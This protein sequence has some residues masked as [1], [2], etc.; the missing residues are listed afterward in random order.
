MMEKPP[1]I[2]TPKP[3]KLGKKLGSGLEK[4]VYTDENNPNQ[5][6]AIHGTERSPE[7]TKA[8]FY[9]TNIFHMLYPNIFRHVRLMGARGSDKE[10]HPYAIMD[11]IE[12]GKFHKEINNLQKEYWQAKD[13]NARKDILNR[14]RIKISE[15]TRSPKYNEFLE[16]LKKMGTSIEPDSLI[17]RNPANYNKDEKGN[18]QYIEEIDPFTRLLNW[19]ELD[20]NPDVL[21]KHIKERLQSE[22]QQRALA[23]LDRIKTLRKENQAKENKERAWLPPNY[24]MD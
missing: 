7:E 6:V 11:E 17:D 20:F 2:N 23:Y 24:K 8:R 13:K 18:V 9:L 12:M 1:K 16:I 21:E 22:D 4:V 5:V 14:L 15:L 3:I 19:V 10:S